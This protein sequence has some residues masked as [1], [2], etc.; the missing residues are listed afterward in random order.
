MVLHIN[1]PIHGAPE[2]RTRS[3]LEGSVW[4]EIANHKYDYSVG[5]P[6]M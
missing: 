2:T 1:T 6:L 3:L 4:I 5:T